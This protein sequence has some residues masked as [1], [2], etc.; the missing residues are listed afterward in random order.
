MQEISKD[1][2]YLH[3]VYWPYLSNQ[4]LWE[5]FPIHWD[6]DAFLV[7]R[8]NKTGGAGLPPV[9][10]EKLLDIDMV[11]QYT[12]H[13]GWL[14]SSNTT[15]GMAMN[16]AL[17]ANCQSIFGYSLGWALCP[18]SVSTRP[19]IMQVYRCV[20]ALPGYYCEAIEVWNASNPNNPFVEC[21]GDTFTI[22][23]YC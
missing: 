1:D 9:T 2:I 17:Q 4:Q 5:V 13:H 22:Q 23:P 10:S 11:T 15:H 6:K 16:I 3:K 20:V 19:E 12:L 8:H 21:S 7:N 18:H 14:G